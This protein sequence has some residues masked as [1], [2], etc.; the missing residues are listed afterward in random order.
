MSSPEKLLYVCRRGDFWGGGGGANQLSPP[1]VKM[2]HF[3][4]KTKKDLKKSF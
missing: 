3:H 1:F 2:I 4:I